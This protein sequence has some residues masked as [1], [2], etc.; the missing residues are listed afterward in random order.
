MIA[1]Q[2]VVEGRLAV[3]FLPARIR[4]LLFGVFRGAA[5][6]AAVLTSDE[7]EEAVMEAIAEEQER[8]SKDESLLDS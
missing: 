8:V 2:R 3:V 5:R 1:S 6:G 4:Q 7:V